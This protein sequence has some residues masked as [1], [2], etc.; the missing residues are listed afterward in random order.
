MKLILPISIKDQD[1]STIDFACFY[2]KLTKSTLTG[3]FIEQLEYEEIYASNDMASKKFKT[4][5]KSTDLPENEAVRLQ[6]DACITHFKEACVSRETLHK[7]HRDRGTPV[8]KLIM[9]TRFA[10]L[11]ILN[12]SFDP[13]HRSSSSPSDLAKQILNT[14][15][16]P[17][18]LSA[19][20]ATG[21][22][23]MIFAYDGRQ[24]SM[25][26]IKQFTYLFPEL[27]NKPMK[28]VE[29]NLQEGVHERYR[30]KEWLHEHY[31][32]VS[33][34]AIEGDVTTKLIEIAII[35]ANSIMILGAY[36]RNMFS[37]L[38]RESH[39]EKLIKLLSRPL[40]ITHK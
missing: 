17:I 28:V 2:A 7:I 32:N 40:F 33:F 20:N 31:N 10:D 3:V 14:A 19:D 5:I 8:S 27:R 23:E 13:D 30:I 35:N 4:L 36:G 9:E 11:M 25:H 6:C 26:A 39:A 12:P 21:I 29:I 16:C 18:L 37:T 24:S 38:I 1:I 34:V 15:E 22:E